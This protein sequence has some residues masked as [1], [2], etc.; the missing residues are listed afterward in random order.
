MKYTELTNIDDII[1]LITNDWESYLQDMQ[2][3]K[4]TSWLAKYQ[5]R[6]DLSSELQEAIHQDWVNLYPCISTLKLFETLKHIDK[7]ESDKFVASFRKEHAAEIELEIRKFRSLSS[8]VDKLQGHKCV[9]SKPVVGFL[10]VKDSNGEH[11]VYV[12][13]EGENIFGS[14]TFPD[15]SK[16]QMIVTA[17]RLLTSK[18]FSIS[19]DKT[20]GLTLMVYDNAN[21]F[22]FGSNKNFRKG[23]ID[24]RDTLTLG[25][26]Q[27]TLIDNYN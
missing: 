27:I 1:K 7:I 16:Y 11:G 10:L 15:D 4:I 12:I 21:A 3:M 5:Q 24:Y 19:G 6:T 23:V 25:S 2:C 22:V 8:F 13:Y 9:G 26:L 18:H 14:G 20:K 17:E